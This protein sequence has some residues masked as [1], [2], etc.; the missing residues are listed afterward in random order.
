MAGIL[1]CIVILGVAAI[2]GITTFAC[3][4]TEY[5]AQIKLKE[6]EIEMFKVQREL[7]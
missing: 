1:T 3:N 6:L 7:K 5:D 4:K 2:I